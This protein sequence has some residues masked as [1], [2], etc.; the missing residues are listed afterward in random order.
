MGDFKKWGKSPSNRGMILKWEDDT[1]LRTMKL[2]SPVY[3]LK[4]RRF[5]AA[6]KP[7]VYIKL[8]ISRKRTKIFQ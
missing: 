5:C 2:L 3:V 1:P 6:G 8:D 4:K 7:S